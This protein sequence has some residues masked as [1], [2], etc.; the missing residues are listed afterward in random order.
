[1][2]TVAPN[3]QGR[4][5]VMDGLWGISRTGGMGSNYFPSDSFICSNEVIRIPNKDQR[6]SCCSDFGESYILPYL[7]LAPA[8]AHETFRADG[9]LR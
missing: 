6:V 9:I 4:H 1:M 3:Q 2:A 7:L 5:Q 8:I